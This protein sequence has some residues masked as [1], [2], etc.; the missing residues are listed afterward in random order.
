MNHN[1][2]MLNRFFDMFGIYPYSTKNQN[3]VKG[4]ILYG[5]MAALSLTNY[6]CLIGFFFLTCSNHD[7]SMCS[8]LIFNQE[9]LSTCDLHV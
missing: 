7:F 8:Y 5:T 1:I 6:C 9:R 3:Y 4:L 2:L